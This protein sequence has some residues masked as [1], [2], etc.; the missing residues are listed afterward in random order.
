M[1]EI[2]IKFCLSFII[3]LTS[4][5][6]ASHP[7]P[8]S[9]IAVEFQ[10][11]YYQFMQDMADYRKSVISRSVVIKFDKMTNKGSIA[12]CHYSQPRHTIKVQKAYWNASSDT[13]KRIIMYHELGHCILYRGHNDEKDSLGRPLSIMYPKIIPASLF[14]VNK[15]YYLNELMN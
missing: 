10:S 8:P 6:S 13:T 4:C 9:D 12:E 2:M 1:N 7:R 14:R 15:E 5:G 3:L 11:Y